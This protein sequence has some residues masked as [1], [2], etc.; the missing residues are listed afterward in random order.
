MSDQQ[1]SRV[2][3]VLELLVEEIEERLWRRRYAA[4]AEVSPAEPVTPAQAEVPL[5]EPEPAVEAVLREP[6]PE[7][8]VQQPE[9]ELEA[10]EESLEMEFESVSE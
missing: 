8:E 1:S 10:E 5:P 4:P 9:L 7:P 6:E 3:Q 2:E